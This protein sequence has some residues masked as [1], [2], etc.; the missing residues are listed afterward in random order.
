MGDPEQ[1]MTE[2]GAVAIIRSCADAV[3]AETVEGVVTGWNEGAT[4]LYGYT[5]EQM[6]G[7][8]IE[9]LFPLGAEVQE[10]LCR[11]RVAAGLA[12]SGTRCRLRRVDGRLVDVILSRWP[13]RDV[14]GRVVGV[15]SISRQVNDREETDWLV[16]LI[17]GGGSGRPAVRAHGRA[18]HDGQ[19]AGR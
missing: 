4:V 16:A 9:R 7:Q 5:A 10:R 11:G 2:L 3:I 6:L 1:R 8:S 19:R 12:E 18:H 17:V 14:Q 13:V 15:A